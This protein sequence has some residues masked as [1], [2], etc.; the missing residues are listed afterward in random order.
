MS[1]SG[2]FRACYESAAAGSPGL[3]GTVSVS[4]GISPGGDVTTAS[5]AGSSLHNQRVEGCVLRNIKRLHFPAADKGSS[6][7]FPFAFKA[8]KR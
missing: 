7:T 8:S 2:A 3:S 4:F 1:R 5:I 6:A